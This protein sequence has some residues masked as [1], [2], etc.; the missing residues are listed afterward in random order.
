MGEVNA[1]LK[2]MLLGQKDCAGFAAQ[3]GVAKAAPSVRRATNS[4]P[5]RVTLGD[6]KK[7]AESINRFMEAMNVELKLIPDLETGRVIIK[8]INNQGEVIRQIPAEAL[9]ELSSKLGS[10]I[11]LLVNELK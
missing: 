3:T 2:P 5:A 9:V 10:D 4:D 6:P 8:V 1:L 7:I 11:G